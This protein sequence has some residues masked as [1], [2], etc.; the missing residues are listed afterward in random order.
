MLVPSLPD[1]NNDHLGRW[2]GLA[3]RPE[4]HT[5]SS[6]R[7]VVREH[8]PKRVLIQ[9][10]AMQ[11]PIHSLKDQMKGMPVGVLFL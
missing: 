11:V 6:A 5:D 10:A 8:D 3:K 4:L 7:T 1:L 9:V 2:N